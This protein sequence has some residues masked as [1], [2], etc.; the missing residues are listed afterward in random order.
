[1]KP[2]EKTQLQIR[3]LS[4]KEAFERLVEALGAKERS[5]LAPEISL[6]RASVAREKPGRKE[7]RVTVE[8]HGQGVVLE[9]TVREAAEFLG[10]SPE[11]LHVYLSRGKR[12]AQRVRNDVLY[13]VRRL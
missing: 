4:Q 7:R 1:M 12:M 9:G 3:N 6:L 5:R 11:T 13:V 2:K 10:L 8:A